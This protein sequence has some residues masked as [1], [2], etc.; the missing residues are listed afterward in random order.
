M[1]GLPPEEQKSLDE[2]NRER[3]QATAAKR[4]AAEEAKAASVQEEKTDS[5]SAVQDA[6]QVS[7]DGRPDAASTPAADALSESSSSES[8][9][10]DEDES[11]SDESSG[12]SVEDDVRVEAP[13]EDRVSDSPQPEEEVGVEV[14]DESPMIKREDPL[15][16]VQ[17]EDVL[18]VSTPSPTSL[19]V[20]TAAAPQGVIRNEV[21]SRT[22]EVGPG[23][24][25]PAHTSEAEVKAYVAEQVRRW[26]REASGRIS[27]PYVQYTWPSPDAPNSEPYLTAV[28]ATSTYLDQRI[29]IPSQDDAWISEFRL[30][31]ER[32]SMAR[33]LRAL[34]VPVGLFSPRECV[35]LLQ[36]LLFEGG[37]EFHNLV[38]TWFQMR[39]S[40]VQP[41]V[42]HLVVVALQRLLAVELIE[43][44][45]LAVEA[46]GVLLSVQEVAA[47]EAAVGKR[48]LE[49]EQ[50]SDNLALEADHGDVLM[51][52]DEVNLL[53]HAFARQLT[54]SRLRRPRSPRMSEDVPKSKRPQYRPPRPSVPSIPSA[55][56]VESLTV[57]SAS[58]GHG[59]RA[60]S[61][62]M[63]GGT[64]F[65]RSADVGSSLFGPSGGSDESLPSAT[66]GSR[67]SRDSSSGSSSTWSFWIWNRV[68]H[69]FW[70]CGGHGDGRTRLG[71]S[72]RRYRK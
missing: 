70:R 54:L 62:S 71:C 20:P 11:S 28:M 26:E 30:T 68:A 8:S 46:H 21:S 45:Q 31:R 53:G 17:E 24:P 59:A 5:G 33:D 9:S 32:F 48:R 6:H 66:S 37:F 34:S 36:T 49:R 42:V 63:S 2:I 72:N 3:R 25:D 23:P 15:P 13:E 57:S 29:L 4:R 27:P 43:W 1:Q 60:A 61:V 67:T 65:I 52:D 64:S 47:Q 51:T 7:S 39:V 55:A 14:I 69:A 12:T 41:E 16:S 35:A 40:R 58:A 44:R 50:R 10:G 22:P 38:P 18:E 56:S 19:P